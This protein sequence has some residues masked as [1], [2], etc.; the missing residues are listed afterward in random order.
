MIVKCILLAEKVSAIYI[1]QLVI[2]YFEEK[3][4]I[5]REVLKDSSTF[6]I[7]VDE[8]WTG[9]SLQPNGWR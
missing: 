4:I 5:N 8:M 7:Y 2:E 1:P 6:L 3:E 9:E